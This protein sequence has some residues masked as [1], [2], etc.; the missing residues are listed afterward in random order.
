MRAAAGVDS[1]TPN[2][3]KQTH[4]QGREIVAHEIFFGHGLQSGEAVEQV[5]AE[6]EVEGAVAPE[7][8]R[9]LFC[10]C[11]GVVGVGIGLG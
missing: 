5:R 2:N 3:R 8:V 1:F 6:A 10:C 11:G 9:G 7:D 4:L